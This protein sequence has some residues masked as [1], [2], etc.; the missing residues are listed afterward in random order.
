[1]VLQQTFNQKL[2]K[3]SNNSFQSVVEIEAIFHFQ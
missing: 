1:M 3:S 2:G